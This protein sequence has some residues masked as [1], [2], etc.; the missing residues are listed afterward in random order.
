MTRVPLAVG[1]LA[2]LLMGTRSAVAQA[3][4]TGEPPPAEKAGEAPPQRPDEPPP[5]TPAPAP[6]PS[7]APPRSPFT[8]GYRNGF[9]L[10]SESGDFV[11]RITG[12][13]HADGRFV[14]DDEASA[15]TDS[16]LLR[17]ARPIVSGT[18]AKYFDFYLSPDF[19][20][21]AAVLFDAYI[22]VHFTGKLRFRAGKMKSPFGLERLQSAQNLFF[23]E[24]ALPN[25][26]VPNRDVGLQAHGELADGIFGYQLAVLDGAPDSG[27]IDGDTN[28]SKD[29]A[30]RVFL[31]PWKRRGTS[32]LRGFGFGVA[33]TTGKANG[34]LRGYSSVSQVSVFSYASTVTASGTRQRW[35][36]QAY[37]YLGPVGFL[38]EYVR[39]SH[40]VQNLV[41]GTPTTG[42]KLENSAWSVTG[43]VLLTGEDA[44][45]GNV[46]PKNFFVPQAHKWGALQL[47]ARVN[48]LDVDPASF[49]GGFADATRSVRRATAWGAGINWIWNSNLKY[50]L[51]YERTRFKGGAAGTADRSSEYSV[52]TRLQVSF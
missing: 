13:V 8:A 10:Q 20:G 39:A 6:S 52:Q 34:A 50:L 11:V 51:D 38:G 17:R 18:V 43:S 41:T 21:G 35:S 36:P 26:L 5:A 3:R 19:G 45:Y 46:K 7:P 27:N 44:T 29:L 24:R 15:V 1:A 30:G 4:P 33:G 28:D 25:N 37:F 48:R 2:M 9:T 16:I 49:T 31:Q 12:Y 47:V 32:P 14:P 22:D 40:H 42:A 23:V